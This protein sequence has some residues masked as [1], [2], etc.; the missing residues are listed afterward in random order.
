MAFV[1]SLLPPDG[2]VAARWFHVVQTRIY[3]SDAP[4]DDGWTTHFLGILDGVACWG[5]DVPV[6]ADP[7]DGAA[8]DLHAYFGRAS[9]EEWLV[10]GRAVQLVEWARTHR[11]CGRCA[12][13]TVPSAGERAMRCPACGLLA[14]PRLAPAMITLVTRGDT[15]LLARGIQWNIPMYSCVAGFVEPGES[16][17][18]AVVREVREE[19][20]IDVTA[21][22]YQGSQPWPFPHS[23]MLGFRAEHASGE[24]VCDPTEIADAGWYRRDELPMIPP[25]ISIA[26]KLIDAWVAEGE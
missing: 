22:R 5:V 2:M 18:G 10:A 4:T 20:G 24:I 6:E 7:S 17:E 3:E 13:P 23:L 8:I 9:E 19:V 25:G 11:F 14:Y 1:P 15:A 26:R 21:V 16:L 12:T